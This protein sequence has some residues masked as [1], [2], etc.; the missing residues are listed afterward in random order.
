MSYNY[1]KLQEKLEGCIRL[2]A[3]TSFI[4]QL[5]YLENTERE[6]IQQLTAVGRIFF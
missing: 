2:R 6:Q 3:E 4:F 5:V 1:N